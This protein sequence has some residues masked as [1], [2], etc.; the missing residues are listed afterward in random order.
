MPDDMSSQGQINWGVLTPLQ[1]MSPIRTQTPMARP[2]SIPSAGSSGPTSQDGLGGSQGGGEISP[3]GSMPGVLANLLQNPA[4]VVQQFGQDARNLIGN[5]LQTA[6]Q[7]QAKQQPQQ[8]APASQSDNGFPQENTMLQ[9]V[10]QAAQ[11]QFPNN[12][13][14]QQ[15]AVAQATQESG[16]LGGKPSQLAQKYNNIFGIKGNGPSLQTHE[17]ING[18]DKTLSQEFAQYGSIEDSMKAYKELMNNPRYKGV[19]NAKNFADAARAVQMAGYATDPHYAQGLMQVNDQL[20]HIKTPDQAMNTPTPNIQGGSPIP[21]QME[22]T[23]AF[24]QAITTYAQARQSGITKSPYVVSID[25]SLPATAK[26]LSVINAET[27]KVVMQSEVAQ[28]KDGFSNEPG[29]H[30]SSLG[31]F[32]V[33]QEFNGKHGD[34]LKVMGLS[35]GLNDNAEARAIEVHG[36]DYIGHGKSGHSF[37]C[38]AVPSDVAPKLINLI[39]DGTIIHA[40]AGSESL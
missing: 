34:S 23:P 15:L 40:S 9:Q 30:Q 3:M 28:G 19:L 4:G 31:T 17:F 26:R 14:M 1:D 5:N 18:Q 36:A 11:A 12:P 25:Y 6:S 16:L 29:S 35:K 27:G 33:T 2:A 21:P 39:K 37:G 8:A 7:M 10:Q 32:Q 38:F 13:V 24:H 22:K 20:S